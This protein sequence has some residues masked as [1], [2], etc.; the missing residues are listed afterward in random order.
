MRLAR[1]LSM[2]FIAGLVLG[3][4]LP[5]AAQMAPMVD[6]PR[7]KEILAR[8]NEATQAAISCE[9]PLSMAEQVRIAE[10]TARASGN[11]Y[12]S[13][14]MLATVQDSRGWMR[15]VVSSQGCRGPVVMDRLAFF[16]QQIAPNLR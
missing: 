4:A 13:G 5:A 14:T 7:S 9:R 10:L 2:G 12:L 15:M 11:E 8:Y 16:D 1:T 6:S 3:V